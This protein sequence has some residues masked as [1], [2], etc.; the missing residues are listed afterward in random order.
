MIRRLR[1][2]SRPS[3][4]A[5]TQAKEIEGLLEKGIEFEII[6]IA[7]LGDIDKTTPLALA[8]GSDFFTQKIEE[9]LIAGRID[10]AVHSAKDLEEKLPGELVIAAFTRSISPYECL[11]SHYGKPLGEL[12]RG[13]VIGTSSR[14]R[15]EALFRF[16]PDLIVKDIRGNV[17]ERLAQ[18]DKGEFDAIIMAHAALLRLG[19]ENRISEIIPADIIEPHPLQGRL[20]VQIRRDRPDL[21]R[22]FRRIDAN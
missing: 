22:I 11:V 3:R 5:I 13:A 6:P 18:L 2:G 10:A 15:K 4:L 20:A 17:E 8:E 14:K 21:A 16:R 1:L 9:A 7:T 19:Y 12:A